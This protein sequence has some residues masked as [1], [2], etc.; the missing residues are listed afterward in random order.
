MTSFNNLSNCAVK[1]QTKK[2]LQTLTSG[3]NY[4]QSS[5]AAITKGEIQLA[6]IT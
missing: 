5:F 1:L 3:C 6:C 4:L 2:A